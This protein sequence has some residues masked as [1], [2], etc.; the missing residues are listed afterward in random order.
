MCGIHP[1]LDKSCFDGGAACTD[2]C[3]FVRLSV[4]L[5]DWDEFLSEVQARR[6]VD[7]QVGGLAV[8]QV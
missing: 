4:E 3:Y 2:R 8:G 7:G 1:P 5:A 6:R